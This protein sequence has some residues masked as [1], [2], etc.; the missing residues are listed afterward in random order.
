MSGWVFRGLAWLIAML[1]LL[2]VGVVLLRAGAP[3][4]GAWGAVVENRLWDHV[5]QTGL[6]VGCV[7]A[8]AVVLGVPGAWVVSVYDFPGRWLM[9]WGLL[10]PVA[11]PGFVAAVAY[12]DVLGGLVPFYIWVRNEWGIEAFLKVQVVMPWVFA[13]GVLGATLYP[14]VFLSCR[15]L[16][17]KQA[18]GE[19]EAARLLGC[20]SF[21]VFMKVALPMAR[22]AVVAG[23]S[24]VVMEAMNDYGV[25]S[26]FGLAPLTP[27]IFRA[28]GEGEIGVAMRLAVFL[29]AFLLVV[30]GLER[31][32]RG[33][34]RFTASGA[35]GVL[36][37]KK[38][39][40]GAGLMALGVCLV[41][42]A[43]GFL[44]PGVRLVR[45]AWDSR[46][47]AEFAGHL[48]AGWNSFSLAGGAAVVVVF[49]AL[50]LVAGQRVLKS[51]GI[52]VAQKIGLMG[53]GF[54]GALVA[55]GVGAVVVWIS[56]KFPWA[57]GLAL[58]ASV[59]GLM[60]AYFVRYLAVGIQ[61]VVAGFERVPGELRDA[62]RTLGEQPFGAVMRVDLPLV[63]PAVIAGATLCFIDVFKELTLTLVLRPFDFETLATRTYRLTDE[64]R[65]AEA[66]LPGLGL[67]GLCLVG[68]IPLMAW[69]KKGEA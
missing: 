4:G 28:W 31:W 66:A 52:L 64:G 9:G 27:G 7:A 59:S 62:A 17:A 55:V 39:G 3:V 20:G 18:A 14:Y 57:S 42:L 16:F 61:P 13:V 67:V 32:Q 54:P 23:G 43:V 69:M 30:L 11:M 2:P 51:R 24:L 21:G 60:F 49:G 41:P 63:W 46:G 35:E 10:L 38:L 6:L 36:G 50:L 44:V 25:V 56:Q 48:E 26:A 37:R 58:S 15:A 47:S 12:V 45:W 40:V 22:P 68:L 33:R 53:Y 65:M 1:V 5:W 19:L 29:M 8:V 34:R